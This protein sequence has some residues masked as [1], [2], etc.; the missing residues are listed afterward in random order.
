M[1]ASLASSGR[2]SDRRWLLV[3][4]A[5]FLALTLSGC[6]LFFGGGDTTQS[7]PS[8]EEA[9]DAYLSLD[10]YEAT[11][12]YEYKDRADRRGHIQVDIDGK[13]SRLDW[14]A[15]DRLDGNMQVFN[16]SAVVRYNATTN[17][18]VRIATSDL[19]NFEDGAQRIEQAVNAAGEDGTTTVDQPA[20]GGAPL[21]VVPRGNAAETT[22]SGQFE[23]SYDGT[24]TVAGREAH[25]ISYEAVDG[26]TTGI[27]EETVWVDTEYF[28]TLKSTQV[29]RFEGEKST[30]TFRLSN[31][32]VDPG[33]TDSDFRFD[34]PPN[35]MLNESGSYSVTGYDTRAQ[36]ARATALSVPDPVVPD[37]FTLSRATHIVGVDFTAV[38]LQYQTGGARIFVTKTT[39]QGYTNLTDGQRVTIG[40]QSGRYRASETSALVA[41]QCG[42]HV[43]TVTGD[44]K[45]STLLDVA[46]SVGCE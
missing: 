16:G 19:D 10:G 20:S 41:W 39:E 34:P 3:G 28:F 45:K 25:V 17:E 11:V 6:S 12:H 38:Q 13:N 44:V 5:L 22:T 32:T 9:A 40:G 31:V 15:P 30:F 24:E 21:P 43:Y 14:L 35:A 23:V 4:L 8:G 26:K 37:R 46:R 7:L 1:C 27:V 33:L 18:Y 36:V 29:S 2:Q 42:D